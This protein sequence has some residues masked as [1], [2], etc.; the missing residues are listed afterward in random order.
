LSFIL[1]AFTHLIAQEKLF[2]SK[3]RTEVS[4]GKK[5]KIDMLP[6]I[7]KVHKVLF[8]SSLPYPPLNGFRKLKKWGILRIE[9][10]FMFAL[11]FIFIYG[12]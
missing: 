11:I 12:P 7:E 5:V 2:T 8:L 3:N 9:L 6:E 4:V 1:F 10:Q